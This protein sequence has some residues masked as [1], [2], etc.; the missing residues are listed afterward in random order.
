MS[1]ES[2]S[3]KMPLS[4]MILRFFILLAAAGLV[5]FGGTKIGMDTNIW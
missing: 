3:A 1:E 5:G 4:A 2:S